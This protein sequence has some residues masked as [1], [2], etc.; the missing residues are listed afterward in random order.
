MHGLISGKTRRFKGI[1]YHAKMKMGRENKD[2][3]GVK[4]MLYEMPREEFFRRVADGRTPAGLASDI[5]ERLESL[6]INS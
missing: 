6:N 4:V 2:I 5:K 1:R 3:C